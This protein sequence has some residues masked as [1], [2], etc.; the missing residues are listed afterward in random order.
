MIGKTKS[1]WEN[2]DLNSIFHRMNPSK[3]SNALVDKR[4]MRF[5]IP[6][7]PSNFTHYRLNKSTFKW[8]VKKNNRENWYSN[9]IFYRM[10][11]SETSNAL[12]DKC[13]MRFLI[14]FFPSNFTHYRLNKSTFKWEVKKNP[15]GKTRNH[16]YFFL[17]CLLVKEHYF[18]WFNVS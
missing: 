15:I 3:M 11:P 12:V 14:P 9:S 17:Y 1:N 2:W 6:F 16:F 10:N 7:F 8:E 4:L 13:L 18:L 5:I